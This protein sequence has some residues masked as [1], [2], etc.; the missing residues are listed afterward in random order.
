MGADENLLARHGVPKALERAWE[1]ADQ[2]ADELDSIYAH[3]RAV[4]ENCKTT[5]VAAIRHQLVG[6]LPE[7]QGLDPERERLM[8]ERGMGHLV[9]QRQ[10]DV[11]AAWAS[12]GYPPTGEDNDG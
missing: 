2:Q 12:Y 3:I 8:R 7:C 1:H 11:R 5:D 9:E 4:A 10:A 6:L